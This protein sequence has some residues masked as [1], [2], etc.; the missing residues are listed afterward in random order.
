MIVRDLLIKLGFRSDTSQLD[1]TEQKITGIKSSVGALGV[2]AGTMLSGLAMQGIGKAIGT[3]KEGV[4]QS[5]Q[6]GR[7][8]ANISSILGGGQDRVKE[9]A[10]GVERLSLAYGVS[11]SDINDALYDL[12]G[13]LGDSAEATDQLELAMKL[14]RAGAATTK[15]GL[16]VLTAVTKAYGD[17]SMATMKKVADLASNTVELGVITMPELASSIGIATPLAAT[18]G[19][20]I[21]ELMANTATLTG[22]TGT[23]SE[24][25]HQFT[26]AMRSVVDR[27][28]PMDAAFKKAFSEEKF[29]S[30]S[31]AIKKYGMIGTLQR[32]VATTDG[33]IESVNG[34][35]GRI[36][37]LNE[38]LAITGKLSGNFVEKQDSMNTISGKVDTQLEKQTTGLGKAGFE[39]DKAKARS[40]ALSRQIGEKMTPAFLKFDETLGTIKLLFVDYILPFF[41]QLTDQ[42]PDGAKSIDMLTTSFRFLAVA[43]GAV[44]GILDAILTGAMLAFNS[45]SL[46]AQAGS[47]VAE[48]NFAAAGGKL[49]RIGSET[50]EGMAGF[51]KRATGYGDIM[52]RALFDVPKAQGMAE[53]AATAGPAGA[54]AIN[55]DVGGISIT[56]NAAPGTEAAAVSRELDT[57]ARGLWDQNLMQAQAALAGDY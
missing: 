8:M 28:K 31:E 45:L 20:S 12:I 32:L 39:M 24:V 25:M 16:R 35:F 55:T 41:S 26:S 46:L 18:L 21:E 43:A 1:K 36:E 11:T 47:D 19:I 15:D 42:G 48:G 37:G 54:P 10:S 22:V 56:V 33:S 5:V 6:F 34:L 2:A 53:T 52:G 57:V 13:T 30:I 3:L 50:I 51:K 29:K 17:T 40:D 4:D 14:G 38:A 44:I 23:G 9:L 27:S 49:K 7:E